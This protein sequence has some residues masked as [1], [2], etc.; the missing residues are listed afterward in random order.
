M[1]VNPDG[2]VDF[3][4]ISSLI[5][6]FSN[7]TS[8][9]LTSDSQVT[10]SQSV[11][12]ASPIVAAPL[13]IV[14]ASASTLNAISSTVETQTTFRSTAL[15][16][17][18]VDAQ[19]AARQR[20]ASSASFAGIIDLPSSIVA[21]REE[22]DGIDAVKVPADHLKRLLSQ[23]FKASKLVSSIETEPDLSA[24]SRYRP[25]GLMELEEQE[26]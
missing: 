21:P 23:S 6:Q 25:R 9:S 8:Q 16:Q 7:P 1:D 3:L 14:V 4:D 13:K 10:P 12:T 18:K 5:E 20:A 19:P 11:T 26:N 24:Q 22:G 17:A 15:P 2:V